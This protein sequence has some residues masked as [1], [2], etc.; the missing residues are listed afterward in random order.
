MN[1]NV[2][3][4]KQTN[5]F[6][7]KKPDLLQLFLLRNATWANLQRTWVSTKND[8]P[9]SSLFEFEGMQNVIL[10]RIWIGFWTAFT[11]IWQKWNQHC[12]VRWV[13]NLIL[14]NVAT[15]TPKKQSVQSGSSQWNTGTPIPMWPGHS[16][17][18]HS[19]WSE[20][21][22]NWEARILNPFLDFFLSCVGLVCL[23]LW[24]DP[25]GISQ[26]LSQ[27]DEGPDNLVVS[28]GHFIYFINLF[29]R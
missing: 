10:T 29:P 22:R 6:W 13:A 3:P 24:S 20:A 9:E 7:N 2:F 17:S 26:D 25:L 1:L 28:A 21:F 8:N 19:P 14:G 5:W 4:R 23:V 11:Y 27:T 12:K 15:V 16:V 18:D